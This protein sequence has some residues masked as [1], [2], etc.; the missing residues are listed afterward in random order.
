MSIEG[1]RGI[2]NRKERRVMMG[3][4]ESLG[5]RNHSFVSNPLAPKS[6]TE[7]LEEKILRIGLEERDRVEK[8]MES[9]EYAELMRGVMRNATNGSKKNK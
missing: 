3:Y 6:N 7:S 4:R 9:P 5:P 2:P 8:F 1:N